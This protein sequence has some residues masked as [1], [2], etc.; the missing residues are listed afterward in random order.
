[1]KLVFHPDGS[2]RAIAADDVDWRK[3]V[4]GSV[5][6]RAS[7]IEVIAEPGPAYGLY[8]VD[9]SPL[10][11]LTG[12]TRFRVCLARPYRLYA[13]A[14]Q[15]EVAWLAAHYVETPYDARP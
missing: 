5:P 11:M 7:R 9:F 2:V 12:D 10:A 1:M 8:H 6:A 4:P 15:A 14:R 3:L 13:E